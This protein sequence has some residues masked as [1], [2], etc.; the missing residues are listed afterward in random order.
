MRRGVRITRVKTAIS[1]E[2]SLFEEAEA[3]AEKLDISRSQ[4]FSRVVEDFVRQRENEEL[5]E[6]LNA[7]HADSLD[8]EEQEHLDCMW[9]NQRRRLEKTGNEW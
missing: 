4:L 7:A 2:E 9:A 6:R 3:L 5:L 1:I 8:E